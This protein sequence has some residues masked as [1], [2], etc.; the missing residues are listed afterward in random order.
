MR[1]QEV[2][3]QKNYSNDPQFL[4]MFFKSISSDGKTITKADMRKAISDL[5]LRNEVAT[6]DEFIERTCGEDGATQITF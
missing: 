1:Y 5:R 6:S 3:G 4:K 2:L